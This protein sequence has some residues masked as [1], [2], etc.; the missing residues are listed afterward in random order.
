MNARPLI[1]SLNF[2]RNAQE[3]GGEVLIASL[4]RLQD[5][6]T[7]TE[8][9]IDFQVR[10]VQEKDQC[11][12]EVSINGCLHLC[13]QRCL[14]ELAFPLSIH[15]SLPLL[16]ADALAELAEDDEFE[17]AIEASQQLDVV[18]LIEDEILLALPFAPKHVNEDC[19]SALSSLK[20]SASPFAA[21]AILKQ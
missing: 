6:L 15:V 13:C 5:S 8:G 12:F 20:Q 2:A 11:F 7:R 18:A 19:H 16:T 4:S 3:L 21:L 1:D 10:G 14:G 17:D 9:L